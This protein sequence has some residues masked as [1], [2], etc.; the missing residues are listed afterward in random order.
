MFTNQN[1]PLSLSAVFV[2]SLITLTIIPH[3]SGLSVHSA[4]CLR[5]Y[6]NVD[7]GTICSLLRVPEKAGP[8]IWSALQ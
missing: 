6:T 2:T 3:N 5:Q 8:D 7:T 1:V 4:A